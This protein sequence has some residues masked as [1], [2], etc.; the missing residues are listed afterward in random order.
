MTQQRMYDL[1]TRHNINVFSERVLI[2]LINGTLPNCAMGKLNDVQ[3]I[4]TYLESKNLLK[5]LSHP[6]TYSDDTKT[7]TLRPYN[8]NF[9][10]FGRNKPVGSKYNVAV[11]TDH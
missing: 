3:D 8:L 4:K 10:L 6:E 5:Y 11:K 7:A 9:I 1:I 2:Q